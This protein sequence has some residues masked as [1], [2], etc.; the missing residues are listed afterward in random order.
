MA[1]QIGQ[2]INKS[3]QATCVQRQLTEG[4]LEFQFPDETDIP[5]DTFGFAI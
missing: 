4:V 3:L 5:F 1:E 2:L